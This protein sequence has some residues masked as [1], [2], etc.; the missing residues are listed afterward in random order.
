MKP[1]RN[2]PCPCGSGRKVK[3]CCGVG[4]AR[5]RAERSA[6]AAAELLDLAT[7]FPRYRPASAAFARWARTAPEEFSKEALADGLA[8]LD[9]GERERI[10]GGFAREYPEMWAS[11]LADFGND[12]LATEIVLSGAVVAGA[13]ESL[14]PPDPDGLDALEHDAE[15]RADLAEALMHVLDGADLWSVIESG[16]AGEIAHAER[17]RGPEGAL[18]AAADRL[19]TSWHDERLHLL[20]ERVRERLPAPDHPLA[21]AALTD[22]CDAFATDADLRRR[23]RALMLLDS[24]PRLLEG[25][26]DAA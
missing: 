26:A 19:A 16:E 23:L 6:G 1:G 25:L 14:R 10:V 2:E 24:L 5:E 21:S 12:E 3:R 7:H 13:R 8:A 11:V 17:R 18:A 15:R 22:A 20:V 4:E 9:A